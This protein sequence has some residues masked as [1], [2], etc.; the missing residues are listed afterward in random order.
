MK[1]EPRA[2]PWSLRLICASPLRLTPC[3]LLRVPLE[4]GVR[5]GNSLSRVL[6][7]LVAA[8]PFWEAH[9]EEGKGG[10]CLPTKANPGP[11]VLL[12]LFPL[13]GSHAHLALVWEA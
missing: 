4:Q 12:F 7:G 5:W 8:G 11:S 2:A 6:W 10:G 3:L 13:P 1:G 9:L